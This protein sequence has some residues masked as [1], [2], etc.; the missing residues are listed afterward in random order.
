MFVLVSVTLILYCLIGRAESFADTSSWIKAIHGVA[1][2]LHSGRTLNSTHSTSDASSHIP[3]PERSFFPV[4]NLVRKYRYNQEVKK[5]Q[6]VSQMS[7]TVTEAEGD[8][9]RQSISRDRR[10]RPVSVDRGER[11]GAAG[12]RGSRRM[13]RQSFSSYSTPVNMHNPTVYNPDPSNDRISFSRSNSISGMSGT[14]GYQWDNGA[15]P[16]F[17]RASFT[18]STVRPQ[19][20]P[21]RRTSVDAAV[22]PVVKP[23]VQHKPQVPTS[24][25]GRG[26]NNSEKGGVEGAGGCGNGWEE[27]PAKEGEERPS[28]YYHRATRVSRWDLPDDRVSEALEVVTLT[29]L[30][31]LSLLY[32]YCLMID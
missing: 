20:E 19:T 21:V 31:T 9:C 4:V 17:S 23:L 22:S 12:Q 24:P 29:V 1:M 13:R 11:G 18:S 7:A 3:L 28:Y 10:D 8:K 27:V 16:Q 15:D 26:V 14:N 5:L 6:G 2:S 30:T 25:Q 32:I